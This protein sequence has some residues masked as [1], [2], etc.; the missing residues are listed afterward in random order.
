[1]YCFIL[2]YNN[3]VQAQPVVGSMIMVNEQ[4]VYKDAVKNNV[5][6]CMPTSYQIATDAE[7]KPEFA[8]TQ[9]R[10]TGT[11]AA[12]DAG[13]KKFHNRLQFRII[14]SPETQ[15][16]FNALK[17]ALKKINTNAILQPLPVRKF[18]S[19]LVF[20][21]IQHGVP[22]A[23]SGRIV[24]I[25][26]NEATDA[27]A[28][29][30]NSYWNERVIA[31]QLTNEDAML[32]ESAIKNNQSA[33]SFS[34]A[35]YTAFTEKNA[36]DLFVQGNSTLGKQI[37]DYFKNELEQEKD[38]AQ[39]ITMIQADAINLA[40][41]ISKWPQLILKVDINEKLPA[42]YALFDVYCYD[43]N[44]NLRPDLFSK[45]IEIKAFSVNGTE[46]VSAFAFKQTRPDL[47]AKSIRFAYAVRFDKPIHYRVT[48]IDN[49]G[50]VLTTEWKLKKEWSDI[51][52]ITSSA[53]KVIH[54]PK[55]VD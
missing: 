4:A 45:K 12:G 49:N 33:I 39:Q 50:E 47:Y 32:I 44:N 3:S 14:V 51:I 46:I 16:K 41:N 18:S 19:V 27:G 35:M 31:L 9:L 13:V 29:V 6:Y 25:N 48:E 26:H 42:K 53:D 15:Q 54:Q 22:A 2:F 23:D 37:K 11:Q 7:G 43:F 36:R 20:A 10:Y 34:Y 17:T 1:M 21:S 28:T 24:K 8:L 38:T 5:Y 55:D 30:N 52:D 40:V